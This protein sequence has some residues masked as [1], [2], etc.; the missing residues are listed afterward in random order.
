MNMKKLHLVIVL[1]YLGASAK[2]NAQKSNEFF[3]S[4][5]LG[6]AASEFA[7]Y[8]I[9]G[10]NISFDKTYGNYEFGLIMNTYLKA[11]IANEYNLPN[12]TLNFYMMDFG[13]KTHRLILRSKSNKSSVFLGLINGFSNSFIFK[14][15]TNGY[16]HILPPKFDNVL[17]NNSFNYFVSPSV[18]L[19]YVLIKNRL[20]VYSNTQFRFLFGKIN[21][22]NSMDFNRLSVSI[23][24]KFLL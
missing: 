13:F 5:Q 11:N 2:I 8:E 7:N 20:A 21:F 6:Y 9:K 23:G 14:D 12:Q 18:N 10:V 22:S 24:A 19:E 1:I 17:L 16:N 15:G 4:L 3:T